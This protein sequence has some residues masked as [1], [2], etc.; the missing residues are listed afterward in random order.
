LNTWK[1]D[2]P[3]LANYKIKRRQWMKLKQFLKATGVF[4]LAAAIMLSACSQPAKS[5]APAAPTPGQPKYGGILKVGLNG[6][7]ANIDMFTNMVGGTAVITKVYGQTLV[8]WQGKSDMGAVIVPLLAKSWE[9]TPDGLTWT[10]HLQ[11]GV[12][13]Q[14]IPP[15]NG[16]E[17]TAEDFV[18]HL[19]RINDPANKQATRITLDMKNIELVDKY[20][21]KVT[22]NRQN[23]GLLVYL[24]HALD[25]PYPK[26]VVEAPGG[27]EKN[28][29]G[30][31]AFIMTDAQKDTKMTFKKNPDYWEKGKPYLDGVEFYVLN[32]T[33]SA[34]AAFR[35]GQVDVLAYQGKA[36]KDAILRTI[37]DAQVQD[38]V[39][40]MDYGLLLNNARPPFDN[41]LVRQAI[42]YSLDYDGII[43]TALDGGGMRTGYL[44]PL[45]TEWGAK[46]A[47]QLPKRD[48]AKAK[49][50]L[51]QAGYP[52]GFK[53]TMMQ[54]AGAA[55][56][57]SACEPIVAML[58]DVG[59]QCSIIPVDNA[60][61]LAKSRAA[62]YDMCIGFVFTARPYDVNNS[63]SQMWM[64]KSGTN[65]FK[66]SNPKV[67]E[68]ILAQQA[69]FP[70]KSKRIPIVKQVLSILDDD[71]PSIP[72]YLTT[73]Y[74]I[75]QPWVKG[76][77]DMGDPQTA[78]ASYALPN[79]WIDK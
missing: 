70:D 3:E 35:A 78:Y 54:N 6:A 51:A 56:M 7:L 43:A 40:L 79:V 10:F 20:T 55:A 39:G 71:V 67:D 11:E 38:G 26:E 30:T 52:D 77:D 18:Y 13:F 45:F 44:A 15:V 61:F 22:T 60:S 72:L 65:V 75:K 23:P 73:S 46:T 59:I 47:D 17:L 4:I 14:N 29:V 58:K 1:I 66:Y 24:A 53:T 42:Q 49:A 74:F 57:G 2:E 50:L 19:N 5:P 16:R 9:V 33:A 32:D 8:R 27:A 68:L 76:W 28:W 12:K 62:D 31:G 25:V 21:F 63:I 69:A 48:V 37:P 34:L 41:K 36:N 64:T